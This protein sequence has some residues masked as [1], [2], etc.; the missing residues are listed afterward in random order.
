MS[1]G[2]SKLKPS[3]LFNS[4]KVIEEETSN[5]DKSLSVG[6]KFFDRFKHR[7]TEENPFNA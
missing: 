3:D 5:V 4:L 6:Q 7:L 1:F 2:G